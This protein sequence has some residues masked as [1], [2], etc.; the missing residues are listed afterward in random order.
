MPGII[1]ILTNPSMP[2]IVKIGKTNSQGLQE[3]MSRLYNTSVALPFHCFYACEVENQDLVE[4]K[5]HDAF[6]DHRVNQSREFFEIDPDRV[7]S[8]LELAALSDV[9][10]TTEEFETPEDEKAV[11]KANEMRS[12]INFRMLQIPIGSELSFNKDE[13]IKAIVT[14]NRTIKYNDKETSLSTAALDILTNI[15][16]YNW[17]SVS[18]SEH[19]IFDGEKLTERRLR[20]E[21]EED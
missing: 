12:R 14:G 1:Y 17:T 21:R 8:A 4:K 11:K 13:N 18:G 19:W 15:F 3:R 2:G 6:D 20:L 7:K 5:L 16:G 9:T 10:P